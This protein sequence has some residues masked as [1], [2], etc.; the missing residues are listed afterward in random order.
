MKRGSLLLCLI[1]VFH[2]S[3]FGQRLMHGLGTS[4]SLIFNIPSG[5]GDNNDLIL[6]QISV[7]YFPRYNFIE[8]ENSSVSVGAPVG[9]GGGFVTNKYTNNTQIYFSFD[10]PVVMDYNIGLKSTAENN[11][12]FGFYFGVGYSYYNINIG[13]NNIDAFSAKTYGPLARM[14]ARFNLSGKNSNSDNTAFTFGLFYKKG[15]ENAKLTTIGAH[16]ILEF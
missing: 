10:I 12:Q 16:I 11:K 5:D 15:I 3:G 13:N 2:F 7:L 14:G 8:R 9:L 4:T 6:K 1:T